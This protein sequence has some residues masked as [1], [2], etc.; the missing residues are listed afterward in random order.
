[1]HLF[2]N[3]QQIKKYETV[4]EIIGEYMPIRLEAY[5]KRKEYQLQTMKRH[6][7]VLTN[8]AK[9]IKE[10]CE[11][12]LTLKNK[13]RAEIVTLLEQKGYD[14]LEGDADYKYLRN[15]PMDSVSVEKIQELFSE[16][17]QNI[18]MFKEL[19]EK[20]IEDIWI[21][22]LKELNKQYALYRKQRKQ[23]NKSIK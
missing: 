11:N 17:D 8:K 3:K 7:K 4:Y 5:G 18:K 13:K 16:R 1:M 9:F 19:N 10:Q 15:M 20:K 23:R 21:E 12:T 6:V 22:E 2:N 14:K